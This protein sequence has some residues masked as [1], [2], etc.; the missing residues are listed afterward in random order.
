MIKL[1]SDNLRLSCIVA[2]CVLLTACGGGGGGSTTNPGPSTNLI[3]YFSDF[4]QELTLTL[5]GNNSIKVEDSTYKLAETASTCTLTSDPADP[6]D[7]RC[8]LL[9][10]GAGY[11]LCDSTTMQGFDLA[12]FKQGLTDATLLEIAG[13]VLQEKTCSTS[14]ALSNGQTTLTFDI[15]SG[16]LVERTGGGSNTWNS[17]QIPAL[18]STSGLTFFGSKVRYVVKK[19]VN[20]GKTTF[21]AIQIFEPISGSSSFGGKIY[22][23]P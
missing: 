5:D 15:I 2:F 12:L 22:I 17:T 19:R 6:P 4:L 14:G 21:F 16:A 23:S 10:N 7:P 3:A 20:A 1:F 18:L 13:L 11:L 8:N 9:P